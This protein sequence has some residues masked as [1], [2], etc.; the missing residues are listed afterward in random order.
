MYFRRFATSVILVGVVA[1]LGLIG[2]AAE[3][4]TVDSHADPTIDVGIVV[5]DLEASTEFYRDVVGMRQS[6]TIPISEEFGSN[7]GLTGGQPTEIRAMTLGSGDEA[8]EWK[9]MTFDDLP[10]GPEGETHITDQIGM[11]Y[12]TIQ[13]ERMGPLLER[14]EEHGFEPRGETPIPL[15][16]EDHFA[17]FQAPEGT[18]VEIIGPL[19]Q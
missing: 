6:R 5:E 19:E 2:V 1:F 16:E 17:L 9:L 4:N 14:A 18:F 12:I 15:G 10:E 11:Q 7:S 3:S 13:V 8:T